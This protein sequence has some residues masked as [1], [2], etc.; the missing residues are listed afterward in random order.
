[1][2]TAHLRLPAWLP[3]LTASSPWMPPPL[4]ITKTRPSSQ[5]FLQRFRKSLSPPNN[6]P[7]STSSSPPESSSPMRYWATM[8]SA[9]LR[10]VALFG[11]F[12]AASVSHLRAGP[13]P[14]AYRIAG[15]VVDSVTGQSLEGAEVTIAPVTALDDRSEERRVGKGGRSG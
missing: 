8:T 3:A 1:M 11:F 15:I 4:S 2:P 6:P 12:L 13:P 14:A 5:R 10:S 7:P 9:V